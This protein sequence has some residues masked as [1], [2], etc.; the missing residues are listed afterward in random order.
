MCVR[1][2]VIHAVFTNLLNWSNGVMTE[3]EHALNDHKR[4]LSAIG[5]FNFTFWGKFK[6]HSENVNL[7]FSSNHVVTVSAILTHTY[8]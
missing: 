6:T 1:F 5:H 7:S 4:R 3:A 8:M 2:G